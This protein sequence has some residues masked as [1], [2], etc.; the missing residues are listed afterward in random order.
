MAFKKAGGLMGYLSKNNL[1]LH[2]WLFG[3]LWQ[4]DRLDVWEN[5]TLGNGDTR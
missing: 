2:G 5:T 3:L 4:Q 1:I